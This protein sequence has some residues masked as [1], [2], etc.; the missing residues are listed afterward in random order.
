M[1]IIDKSVPYILYQRTKYI[2]WSFLIFYFKI[3]MSIIVWIESC[4]YKEKIKNKYKKDMVSEFDTIK[5]YIPVSSKRILDIGCGVAGIDILIYQ[6]THAEIYLL[7]KTLVD[8]DVYY[9]F[10][11]KGSYYNS[12]SIAREQLTANGVPDAQIHTQEV[13]DDYSQIGS[14]QEGFDLI[15]SLIS[16][17]FHYPVSVYKNQVYKNLA[18]HGVLIID[19]RKDSQGKQELEELFSVT[20]IYD[21]GKYVRFL[22]KK[23]EI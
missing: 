11:D 15:I 20:P 10:K 5:K 13:V 2:E 22:C 23:N 18:P 6:Q 4:L 12:L 14:S 21:F 3:P 9:G 19:I 16:W 8:S 17:G 1:I 7:D